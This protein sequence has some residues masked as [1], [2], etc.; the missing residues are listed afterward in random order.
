MKGNEGVL[1]FRLIFLGFVLLS[2]SSCGLCASLLYAAAAV[3]PG[4]EMMMTAIP[5]G[6]DFS[7]FGILDIG[8]MPGRVTSDIHSE[9]VC[10]PCSPV[11]PSYPRSSS[12]V[13]MCITSF[14]HL[15]P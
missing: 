8:R 10:G 6:F 13:H 1:S 7:I 15:F 3:C 11:L 2:S 14:I 5:V 4:H 9:H 12:F